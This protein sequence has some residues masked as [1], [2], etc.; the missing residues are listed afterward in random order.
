MTWVSF[1]GSSASSSKYNS[2]Q[3]TIAYSCGRIDIVT[4]LR[5]LSE[6]SGRNQLSLYCLEI[7]WRKTLELDGRITQ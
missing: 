1:S 4:L 6:R 7:K 3:L 2:N 5:L